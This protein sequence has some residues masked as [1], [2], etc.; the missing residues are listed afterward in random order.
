MLCVT[1]TAKAV[2]GVIKLLDALCA[3]TE[4]TVQLPAFGVYTW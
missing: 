2:F 1:D 3:D 4:H